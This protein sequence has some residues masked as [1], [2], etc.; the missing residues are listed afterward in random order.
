VLFTRLKYMNDFEERKKELAK[1]LDKIRLEKEKEGKP[2][3]GLTPDPVRTL[4]GRVY[5][6]EQR[7][8]KLEALIEEWIKQQEA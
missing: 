2:R 6:L 1:A 4:M 3:G 5:D 7:V 8:E